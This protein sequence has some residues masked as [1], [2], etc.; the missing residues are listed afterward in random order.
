[1]DES[2]L[3]AAQRKKLADIPERYRAGYV[4][5]VTMNRRQ[6][7]IRAFCLECTGWTAA[8]TRRCCSTACPLWE[9]RLGGHP[10]A[11]TADATMD[12]RGYPSPFPP[13]ESSEG[14][15]NGSQPDEGP[16]GR[17]AGDLAI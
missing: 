16:A 6:A 3:T 12:A 13:A 10:G 4:E 7:A 14:V 15:G 8:E 9:Y 5:A 11:S 2:K 17:P 1:M